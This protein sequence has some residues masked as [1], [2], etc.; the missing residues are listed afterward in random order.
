MGGRD[1]LF[2]SRATWLPRSKW[3]VIRLSS[4][5]SSTRWCW[6]GDFGWLYKNVFPICYA[7]QVDSEFTTL[8][9]HFTYPTVF[10][11]QW[12]TDNLPQLHGQTAGRW[13]H[14]SGERRLLSTLIYCCLGPHHA[15]Q[16][17]WYGS[18]LCRIGSVYAHCAHF[19]GHLIPPW[20]GDGRVDWTSL[21][22]TGRG[23]SRRCWW[24][25]YWAADI[26]RH[27]RLVQF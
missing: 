2:G 10:K 16:R 22:T 24:L 11:A 9:T 14:V 12:R 23:R 26:A 15:S 19:R 3:K 17:V 25:Y 8:L 1:L 7:L 27:W 20:Q 5:C 6:W 13:E 18:A 4:W 21:A